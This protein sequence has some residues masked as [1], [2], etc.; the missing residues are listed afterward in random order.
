MRKSLAILALAAVLASGTAACSSS[1]GNSA[2]AAGPVATVGDGNCGLT[3]ST[4]LGTK[5][6]VT[7][8]S[9]AV[10]PD[11]LKEYDVVPGTGAQV[12]QG[13]SVTVNYVGV[14]WSTKKEF[15]S[16]WSRNQ[17]FTIAGL[18]SANV[19]LGWNVG[20]IGAHVGGRRVLELPPDMGYGTDGTTG[21]GPNETL[22]F[23]VDVI[24]AK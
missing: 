8:P 6:S 20:L 3:V 10:K 12:S 23:I 24:S 15:D 5:P 1:G 22:V 7:I 9:C 16:S 2:A 17:P 11:T 13:Q 19:I 18:G 4:T 21:V 14:A